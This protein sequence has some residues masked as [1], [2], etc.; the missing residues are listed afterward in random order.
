MSC[1]R[2]SV[3]GRLVSDPTRVKEINGVMK[4]RCTECQEYHLLCEF[5]VNR[6]TKDGLAY[7]CKT[8]A[9]PRNL[10]KSAEKTRLRKELLALTVPSKEGYRFCKP[11]NFLYPDTEEFFRIVKDKGHNL[12]HRVRCMKCSR[13]RST[14]KRRKAGAAV[15]HFIDRVGNRK[16]CSGCEEIKPFSD[17]YKCGAVKIGVYHICISCKIL[18]DEKKLDNPEFVK[19]NKGYK[20]KSYRKSSDFLT[21]G[22]VG[23][24]VAYALQRTHGVR[25]TRDEIP[26][27]LIKK[28]AERIAYRRG[29]STEKDEQ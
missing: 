5:T 20:R 4:R 3:T 29:L 17:F 18:R 12:G 16:F 1:T 21:P 28:T 11:C 25:P 15:G 6:A 13:D 23:N 22:Y 26:E 27:D 14:R 8:C 2:D 24:V 19:R 7:Y 9:H 10:S